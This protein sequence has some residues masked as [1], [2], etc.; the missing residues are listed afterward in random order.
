MR[1]LAVSAIACAARLGRL[2]FGF[3]LTSTTA[4]WSA[5]GSSN[6]LSANC[7]SGSSSS[8]GDANS[9]AEVGVGFK[10]ED[11]DE[12]FFAEFEDGKKRDN[13]AVFSFASGK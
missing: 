1:V 13:H 3:G 2:F 8:S 5:T 4:T 9:N 6:G 11:V 12:S 10:L 7:G